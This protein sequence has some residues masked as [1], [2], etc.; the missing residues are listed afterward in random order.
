MRITLNKF[1]FYQRTHFVSGGQVSITL[2]QP[3]TVP[4]TDHSIYYASFSH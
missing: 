1:F 3:A 2:A 4:A